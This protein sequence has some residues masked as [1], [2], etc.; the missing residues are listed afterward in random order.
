PCLRVILGTLFFLL[1][2][3]AHS[4]AQLRSELVVSGLTTPVAF[5]QDPADPSVQVIVQQNGRIR[6]LKNGVLQSADF[7]DLTSVVLS[8]GEQGLLGLAFAPDY[9]T[10][11]SVFVNFTN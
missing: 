3:S 9:A 1:G 4:E 2:V 10:S 7:L 11:R 8:G 6:V 5:V